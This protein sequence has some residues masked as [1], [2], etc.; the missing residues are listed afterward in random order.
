MVHFAQFLGVFT[1][2]ILTFG[3]VIIWT[4]YRKNISF[5]IELLNPRIIINLAHDNSHG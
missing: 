2:E 1:D 3:K 4:Q 5:G